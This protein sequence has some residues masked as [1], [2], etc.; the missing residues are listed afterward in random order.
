MFLSYVIYNNI[1]YQKIAYDSLEW[2]DRTR[3]KE[4]CPLF[5]KIAPTVPFS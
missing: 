3:N 1:V 2:I 4:N 5:P